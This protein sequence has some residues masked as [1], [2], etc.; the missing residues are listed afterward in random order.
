MPGSRIPS[1]P[2]PFLPPGFAIVKQ[3]QDKEALVKNK[4]KNLSAFA[5]PARPIQ[6]G[7]KRVK[8]V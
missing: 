4:N 7:E 1:S 8:K 5:P 2:Q 3:G 6:S